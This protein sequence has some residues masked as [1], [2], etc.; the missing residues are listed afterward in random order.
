MTLARVFLP[1]SFTNQT[2]ACPAMVNSPYFAL[3]VAII[4]FA[5]SLLVVLINAAVTL[6]SKRL[7]A[8][9]KKDE[10]AFGFKMELNKRMLNAGENEI[11]KL[12]L[13]VQAVIFLAERFEAKLDNLHNDKHINDWSDSTFTEIAGRINQLN[14]EVT[15]LYVSY[16]PITKAYTE[17]KRAIMDCNFLHKQIVALENK[18]KKALNAVNDN[19]GSSDETIVEIRSKLRE[20]MEDYLNTNRDA[21]IKVSRAID[22]IRLRMERFGN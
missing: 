13:G 20:T 5:S 10:Q 22:E 19:T 3:Y 18:E 1:S 8:K 21:T 4:G 14:Q 15:T 2:F 11:G 6:A 9:Q 16:F 12:Y 7:D 17:A